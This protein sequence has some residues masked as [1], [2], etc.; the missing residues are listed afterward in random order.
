LGAE[1]STLLF[2]L[3][4]L[5]LPLILD[6]LPARSAPALVGEAAAVSLAVILTWIAWIEHDAVPHPGARP[7]AAAALAARRRAATQAALGAIEQP[8]SRS[9]RARTRPSGRAWR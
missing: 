3:I 9:G 2:V 8:P 7:P 1:R 5:Q 6:A 4:G